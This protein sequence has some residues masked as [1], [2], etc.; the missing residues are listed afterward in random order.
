MDNA[1]RV[2]LEVFAFKDFNF[3]A[4]LTDGRISAGSATESMV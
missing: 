3:L 2:L 1:E 4:R